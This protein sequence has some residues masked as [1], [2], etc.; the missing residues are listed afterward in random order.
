MPEVLQGV[1]VAGADVRVTLEMSRGRTVTGRVEPPMIADLR[2]ELRR[3]S[4]TDVSS[5]RETAVT[6]ASNAAGEFELRSVPDGEYTLGAT[7]TDGRRGTV[8]LVATG[9][10]RDLRISLAGWGDAVLEATVVDEDGTSVAGLPVDV[11]HPPWL[12]GMRH[13]VTGADGTFRTEQ[14][15]RGEV[16][17]TFKGRDTIGD[18]KLELVAGT[19]RA[20]FVL[21]SQDRALRGTVLGPDGRPARDIWVHAGPSG[22]RGLDDGMFTAATTMTDGNGNFTLR[23]LVRS[24]HGLVAYSSSGELHAFLPEAPFDEPATLRLVRREHLVVRVTHAGAPVRSYQI[25]CLT[26]RGT[27]WRSV[28][29]VDGV[30]HSDPLPPGGAATCLATSDAGHA[31]GTTTIPAPLD[32][33]LGPWSSISGRLVDADGNPVP[34]T[35]ITYL[36]G[37]QRPTDESLLDMVRAFQRSTTTD[38]SGHFTFPHAVPGSG[39][40]TV[41]NRDHKLRAS[42]AITVGTGT[43][44]AGTV[45]AR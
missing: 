23:G 4:R 27:Y 36:H 9:D 8:K 24:P 39:W 15:P 16:A 25:S 20:R 7:A 18:R 32:L 43:L 13:L 45:V 3:V 40:L 11:Q 10:Q 38:A 19:N 37:A 30:Y 41:R 26:D 34:A 28:Q 33:A 31:I 42:H 17:V 2:L 6:T 29:R 12:E 14:L 21:R 5:R 35:A 22:E 1:T 44:D